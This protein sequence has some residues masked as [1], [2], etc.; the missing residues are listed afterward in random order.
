MDLTGALELPCGARLKNRV[1]KAA[2]SEGLADRHD[3]A[4]HGHCRLYENWAR[5]GAGL[6]ITGNVMVDR[7]YLER[8]GNVVLEDES[9]MSRLQA[10]AAAGTL[11]NTHLWMQISHP[12][13]QCPKLVSKAPL[14]PSAVQLDLLGNFAR[15]RA[16]TEDDI[17]NVIERFG[18]TAALA[19]QA[20]FTG[21]QIN[22]AHGY[23]ISQFLSP[24]VNRRDDRWGGSLA[25]RARLLLSI[26]A[27]IRKVVGAHF[28]ISVKLNAADFQRGGFDLADSCHCALWLAEAG[29]DLLEVSGGSFEHLR[30]LGYRGDPDTAE[31][32]DVAANAVKA[33]YFTDYALAIAEALQGAS[34]PMPLMVT[35]GFRTREAMERVLAL[36]GIDVV[37]LARPFCATPDL[38]DKLLRGDTARAE[39]CVQ[40]HADGVLHR[41]LMRFKTYRV[42]RVQGEVAWYARQLATL[43]EG[44]DPEGDSSLALALVRHMSADMA[45]ALRRK[46]PVTGMAN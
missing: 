20:G 24:K 4:T 11:G 34:K 31:D 25:N 17:E 10:W 14:A 23:L 12:G 28:P 7:R 41:W 40:R 22:A 46:P 3:H 8:P 18:K 43:A 30:L 2:M 16:M 38:A 27:R 15:P 26:V 9:G 19:Q 39:L 21:V 1:V 42:L 37:G 33:G 44:R 35:G 5:G 29:V 45:H 13:R 36:G 32:P 6:L